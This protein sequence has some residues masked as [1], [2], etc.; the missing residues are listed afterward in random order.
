MWRPHGPS[1]PGARPL[2]RSR[3]KANMAGGGYGGGRDQ[4][5]IRRLDDAIERFKTLY[6]ADPSPH[7]RT[8]FLF[9]GGL[10][11]QLMRARSTYTHPPFTYYTAWLA[12]NVVF[13]EARHLGL[14][15][16]G[17]DFNQTYVVPD[18][19]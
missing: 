16:G 6:D 2:A 3:R 14:A 11:S 17:V 19:G 7:K 9:P 4:E 12:C 8:L 18:G 15:P 13:G 10:G 1:G 5:Q